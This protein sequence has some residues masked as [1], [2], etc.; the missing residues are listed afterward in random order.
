MQE[1]VTLDLENMDIQINYYIKLFLILI[2]LLTPN[3][4]F[5][6]CDDSLN[7]GVD[8]SNCQFSDSQNLVG[9]Y[10]PNSNLKFTGFIKV[11]FDKSIM[12]NSIMSFGNFSES[13]FFR[14][15]LYEANLEG[16]NFE[17]ANFTSA[18]LTRSNFS[19]SS[20]IGANFTNSNLFEAN[21]IGANILNATFEGA[22]LNN[23]IWIDGK[24]C[25]LGSIGMCI[26]E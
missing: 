10:L 2:L 9:S 14:A 4:V 12:M 25:K 26:K 13:S 8:Y 19:G 1:L 16:G 7:D 6:S 20:L 3:K 5:P 17:K 22:N 11:N 24:K 15:N 18:N 23:A 21:F